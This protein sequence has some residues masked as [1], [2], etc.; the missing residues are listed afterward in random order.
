MVTVRLRP[1]TPAITLI[2]LAPL[3]GEVLN[4]ATRLSFIFAFIPQIMVWGCGTL[5]IREL[6]NRWKG[7]WPSVVLLGLALSVLAEVL[8]L[9]TSIAPLPWLQMASI[10]VY[11]RIW[12]VN[13]L[14]FVFMLGYE[15]VWIVLV[16]ILITELIFPEQRDTP[17][18]GARGLTI[19]AITFVAGC[20][21]LWVLWTQTAV[22]TAFH[23][24]KYWPP[25]STLALGVLAV[26]L[27]GLA[28]YAS[29]GSSHRASRTSTS[30]APAPWIVGSAAVAFAVPWWIVIVLV[31]VPQPS[32]P[33][34]L[35]LLA[36]P[37]WAAAAWLAIARWSRSASWNDRQ[38]W[39]LAF[40][41]LVVCM[42]LGYLGS[43]LW[44][45]IDLIAKVLF[46]AGAVAGMIVLARLVWQ[47]TSRLP[48]HD[49][50]IDFGGAARG[51]IT[52]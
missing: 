42:L 13:W 41:A 51:E 29:R 6:V 4:G 25:R 5:M 34:W 31:F 36:A 22:P 24:P 38:R 11:D 3:V 17:W 9:Q 40:G 14:W 8:I 35:P 16:P 52:R 30:S 2:L 43:S 27:L 33:L 39:A 44:P 20:A 37:I 46:N 23:Q 32:L 47:R 49:D 19:A 45:A 50:R 21:G 12:G 1:R 18:V 48:E 28:A 10:P 26:A 7:G 15:T